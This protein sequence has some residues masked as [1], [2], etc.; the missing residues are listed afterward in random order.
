MRAWIQDLLGQMKSNEQL[1][2]VLH[3]LCAPYGD[4]VAAD[5]SSDGTDPRQ[6]TCTIRMA[7]RPAATSV[8]HWLGTGIPGGDIV[9]L[10][11][12]A[13]ADYRS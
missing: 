4:V 1:E 12:Q 5:V 8:A 9:V 7:G 3:E 13:S 10:Q 11:Y 2:G 6:V